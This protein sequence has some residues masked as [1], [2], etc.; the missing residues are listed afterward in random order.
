MEDPFLVAP[1]LRRLTVNLDNDDVALFEGLWPVPEGV[2]LHAYLLQGA[3]RVIIDPWDAGGYGPEEIAADLEDLGL[4]W[5]DIAAVAF[6]KAPAPDLTARI[7]A[8]QPALEDWGIPA[9][10]ARHDLGNGVFLEARNGFW[11]AE[12]SGTLLSGDVLSGLGWVEDEKWTE[13]LGDHEG[14]Y[15]EDE[16]LRWFAS[17]PQ[18]PAAL[19]AGVKTVAPAHGCLWKSPEKALERARRFETWARD[20]LNEVTV[21]WPAD[22]AG[23]DALVGGA[24]DLGAGL[25]LFRI[26]GDEATALA[27]GARRASLVVVAEGLDETFLR[28]LSKDVW[29]P[30][31]STPAD[32]LRQE[33]VRRWTEE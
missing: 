30:S 1:G 29:R 19:P 6:T 25:N 4:G 23:A 15:F 16:A 31:V 18:V 20:G 13:D 27:A 32:Q 3:K 10:G 5:K 8:F 17:R 12:P 11:V 24:L 9:A 21:V 28:G 7:R 22:D 33:L 26:P 2:A 14:R